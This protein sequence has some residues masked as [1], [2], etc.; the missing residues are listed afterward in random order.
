MEDKFCS[1]STCASQG[2]PLPVPCLRLQQFH[3]IVPSVAVHDLASRVCTGVIL[4]FD[5]KTIRTTTC[6]L[7]A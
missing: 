1:I 6:S 7:T 4:A 2:P 5:P 3:I